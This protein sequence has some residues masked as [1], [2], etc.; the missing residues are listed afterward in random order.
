MKR[1][2]LLALSLTLLLLVA[3]WVIIWTVYRD[4]MTIEP[5]QVCR[6]ESG[7]GRVPCP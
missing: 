4:A 5:P 7:H 3:G 1:D 6:T 2:M